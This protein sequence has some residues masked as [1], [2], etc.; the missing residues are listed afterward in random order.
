MHVYIYETNILLDFVV[1]KNDRGKTKTIT[2]E[3]Y[4]GC[5]AQGHRLAALMKKRKE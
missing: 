1:N 2:R 4:P 5:V 3:K